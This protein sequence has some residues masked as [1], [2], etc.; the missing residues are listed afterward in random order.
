MAIKTHTHEEMTASVRK[1]VIRE[2][3]ACISLVIKIENECA[4]WHLL[5]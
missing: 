1:A 5:S 3:S 2:L 4:P